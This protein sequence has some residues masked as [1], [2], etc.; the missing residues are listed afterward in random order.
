MGNHSGKARDA[1]DAR[2]MDYDNITGKEYLG[3]R[4]LKMHRPGSQNRKK[5]YKA[6]GRRRR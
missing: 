4:G 3:P 2:R 1:L 6:A 5:G